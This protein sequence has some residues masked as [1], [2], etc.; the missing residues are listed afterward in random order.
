V[1]FWSYTTGSGKSQRLESLAP[2]LLDLA[3]VVEFCAGQR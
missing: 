1:R 2:T 3:D